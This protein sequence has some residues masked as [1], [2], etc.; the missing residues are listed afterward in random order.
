MATHRDANVRARLQLVADA[1]V[2][3]AAACAS[4][5]LRRS[6]SEVRQLLT[7]GNYPQSTMHCT[8]PE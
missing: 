5:Q 4:R 2:D 7:I 3:D 6:S 1:S 8:L